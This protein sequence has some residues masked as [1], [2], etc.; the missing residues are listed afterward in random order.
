MD[1]GFEGVRTTSRG[2]AW[3]RPCVARLGAARCPAGRATLKQVALAA[4]CGVVSTMALALDSVARPAG[5]RAPP[6][7]AKGRY[8]RLRRGP[9]PHRPSGRALSTRTYTH[10]ADGTTHHHIRNKP[11]PRPERSLND[12]RSPAPPSRAPRAVV[13]P[14]LGDADRTVLQHKSVVPGGRRAA[15]PSLAREILSAQRQAQQRARPV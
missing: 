1:V 12:M 15:R 14:A 10:P 4:L 9:A 8:R 13:G 5:P 7:R 3:G 2:P 11:R 6:L